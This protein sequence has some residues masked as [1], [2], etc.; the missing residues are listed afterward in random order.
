CQLGTTPS[1]PIPDS[2]NAGDFGQFLI[3]APHEYSFTEEELEERTDGHMDINRVREGAIL[4]CPVKVPGGGI[5]IGDM[6][7]MQGNGEIAGH[8]ADVSGIVN[9]QAKVIKGLTIDGPILL[10]VTED[11]PYLAKPFS[12]KEKEAA[13]RIAGMYGV[14][15]LEESLPVSF[16]GTGATLN[17]ATDN[18]LQRAADI[19]GLSVPE[20]KNRATINGSIEIGR[21]PGVVTV[22]FLVPVHLLDELSLTD[23]IRNHYEAISE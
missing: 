19:L 6:H 5:Y 9:L 8:T 16:I 4:I 15:K 10:P 20:V 14:S 18:G 22:T 23:L 2:H 1:R 17:D 3:D 12:A 7:A 21:H 11:L 13:S